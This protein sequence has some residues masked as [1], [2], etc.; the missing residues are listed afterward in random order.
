V[1]KSQNTKYQKYQERERANE[2]KK[3]KWTASKQNEME[4]QHFFLPGRWERALEQI[5]YNMAGNT[6]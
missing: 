4:N 3:H 1:S 5:S 2:K 6:T